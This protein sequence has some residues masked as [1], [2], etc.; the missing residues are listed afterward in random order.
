MMDTL[1]TRRTAQLYLLVIST[2]VIPS[3]GC[4]HTPY[5][6]AEYCKEGDVILAGLFSIHD[7]TANDECDTNVNPQQLAN[8]EAMV[9]AIEQVNNNPFLL[10]NISLGYRIFDTC[11]SPEKANSLA[12]SFVFDKALDERLQKFNVTEEEF[13]HLL[14]VNKS[15]QPIAVVIGPVDSA[16]AVVVAN[17]LQVGNLPLISPSA[18]S[19]ELSKTH[20][21]TFFRTVAPDSQQAK[22]ISDIIEHFNWTYIAII[23]SESSYG[24]FGARAMEREA[25]ERDTFC[26]HSIEYYPLSGYE[27]KIQRIVSKMKKTLNVLVIVLWAGD[28]TSIQYF[29]QESLKQQ[30][31]DRTW[32]APDGW[33]DTTSLFTPEYSTLIGGFIGT[34]FRQF[35]VSSFEKHLSETKLSSWGIMENKWWREFWQSMSNCSKFAREGCRGNQTKKSSDLLSVMK[36]TS[37]AY[38]IDAVQAAAHAIDLVYRCQHHRTNFPQV[39][40]SRI[41]AKDVSR[42]LREVHFEGLTGSISFD[43]N[44]NSLRSAAYDIVNFQ[45]VSSEPPLLHEVGTWDR[46]L[47]KRLRMQT[48]SI[49]WKNGST[50]IPSSRCS[51][52]CRPGTRQTSAIACCWECVPCL[53]GTISISYSSTNCTHCQIYE[54]ST[55]DNTKC[56]PLP[57]DNLTLREARGIALLVIATTGALLTLFTL[58]VFVKYRNTPVVKSSN[59]N[60]SYVFLVSILMAFFAASVRTNVPTS[61]S[62]ISN[63]ILTAM[64]FNS[65]VSILFLK[66]IRLLHIFNFQAVV[67]G[68]SHWFYNRNYQLIALGILNL[69]PIVLITVF[70]AVK[71]PLVQETILPH[72][73]RI[74]QCWV[75]TKAETVVR[76]I[77]YAYEF[78]LSIMV[79]YCAFRARKLPSNFKET[80]YILF[81]MY[82]QLITGAATFA[83]FSSL[84][85]GSFKE[86]LDCLVHLCRTYSFLVCIFGPKLFIILRHPKKNTREFVKA[87]VARHTMTQSLSSFLT[88]QSVVFS[89]GQ[90]R[91]R[92]DSSR[93]ASGLPLVLDQGEKKRVDNFPT[94]R[95]ISLNHSSSTETIIRDTTRSERKANC[96]GILNQVRGSSSD[97]NENGTRASHNEHNFKVRDPTSAFCLAGHFDRTTMDTPV[98]E[99]IP[100]GYQA[101]HSGRGE[102]ENTRL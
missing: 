73:Y 40:C 34:T 95:R 53:S 21:R 2:S 71:P 77:I 64:F 13:N 42:A 70:L 75:N 84:Q 67:S 23:S 17:T 27:E 60:L 54:E 32:I 18:T 96:V 56:K 24:R 29:F 38:V 37:L 48:S 78:V 63:F 61:F 33:S 86:M 101:I 59:V 31:F 89:A 72:Q 20:F 5:H 8:A 35:N 22:A 93:I 102:G 10:P 43:K 16:S 4:S 91:P 41:L 49:L 7:K 44:G 46:A 55:E 100:L 80:R 99:T 15:R 97:I 83:I 88:E 81:N 74:S 19:D 39:N 28:V 3:L 92:T 94:N 51:Q 69:V 90:T 66:T 52:F 79:A 65:C 11:G 14:Q 25:L 9:Y 47:A 1:I 6:V 36:T 30:L 87:A 98:K 45:V 68:K 58:G 82:I 50:V 76:C 57:L 62:C 85:P 26:I 12:F